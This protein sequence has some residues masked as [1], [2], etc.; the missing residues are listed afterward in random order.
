V[1]FRVDPD[2]IRLFASSLAELCED[3]EI[4]QRYADQIGAFSV[5]ETG[6]IGMVT[7]KHR[8]FMADFDATM[9]KLAV[10]FDSSSVNM[11]ATA[12]QYQRTDDRSAAEI[13]ASHPASPRPIPGVS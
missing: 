6:A 3:T 1:I 7:G 13:D 2:Q 12:N 10:L 4:A 11:Q 9:Q 5:P 8:A